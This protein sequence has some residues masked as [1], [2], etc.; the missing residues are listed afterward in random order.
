MRMGFLG[1][2]FIVVPLAALAAGVFLAV[3]LSRRGSAN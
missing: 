2:I 3:R 1:I